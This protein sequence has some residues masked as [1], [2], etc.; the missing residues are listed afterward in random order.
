S[1]VSRR[2]HASA[3]GPGDPRSPHGALPLG[4]AWDLLE[5]HD[6][7]LVPGDY[8]RRPPHTTRPSD[9]DGGGVANPQAGHD[10]AE[11]GHGRDWRPVQ[12]REAIAAV[13]ARPAP[14][15]PRVGDHEAERAL[16]RRLPRIQP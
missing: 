6:R 1:T 5:S 8:Y 9:L 14:R 11:V 15:A 7:P 16:C 4:R 12:R 2:A 10:R 13:Q 3:W